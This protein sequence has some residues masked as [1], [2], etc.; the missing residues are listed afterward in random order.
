MLNVFTVAFFGHRYLDNMA[1]VESRLDDRI[2]RLI[3]EKEYVEFLVGRNGDF[4]QCASSSLRRAAKKYG[5]ANNALVLVL[6][7]ETSEYR[8]NKEAFHEYYTDVEISSA[9]SKAHPKAALSVRNREMVERADMVICY[10]ERASGG[11]YQAVEYAKK[12]GKAVVNLYD[13]D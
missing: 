8:E 5:N 9:A 6:P 12:Q 2:R 13:A 11:A 1:K 4:D 3:T 7:Y 10:V